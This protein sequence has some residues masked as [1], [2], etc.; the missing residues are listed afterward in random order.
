MKMM[1]KVNLDFLAESDKGYLV[2]DDVVLMTHSKG[3]LFAHVIDTSECI[4]VYT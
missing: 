1:N 3:K 4:Y 2:K